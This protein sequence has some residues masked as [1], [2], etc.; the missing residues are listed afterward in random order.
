[1]QRPTAMLLIDYEWRK[2]RKDA[3]TEYSKAITQYLP[4]GTKEFIQHLSRVQ[5]MPPSTPAR[6]LMLCNVE[7][8]GQ[9]L[10]DDLGN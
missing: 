7:L 3:A 2:I 5:S 10:C 6:Y 1:M 4:R 8:S 9:G